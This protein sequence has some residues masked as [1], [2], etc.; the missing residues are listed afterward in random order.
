MGRSKAPAKK[1]QVRGV[2]FKKFKKK[3][4]RKLPPPKNATNIEIKAKAII[5][6]EQSVALDK[7]GVP[8]SK[9]G[10]TLKELLHQTSHHNVKIRRD[11]LLGIRELLLK[12]PEELKLH[13]NAAIE[14]LRERV[15]DDDK[16]VREA[17]YQLFK[18]VILPGCKEDIQGAPISLIMAYI[19]KAMTHLAIDVRFMAFKFFDLVVQNYPPSF[20]TYAEK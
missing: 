16:V 18:S 2:D 10:L 8:V 1:P 14:K 12:F 15:S 5:L 6:P 3:L 7:E 13:K 19:F 11:A 9:K 20:S 4:G 17:L